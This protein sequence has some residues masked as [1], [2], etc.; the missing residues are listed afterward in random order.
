[1]WASQGPPLPD[2]LHFS[3]MHV[4]PSS[5]KILQPPSGQLRK[6][7]VAP[8]AHVMPQPPGA[9]VSIMHVAPLAQLMVQPPV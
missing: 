5:H 8:V 9:Q 4:A 3:M 6:M 7:Q 2:E 1:M